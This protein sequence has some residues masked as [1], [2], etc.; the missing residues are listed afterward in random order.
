LS[1]NPNATLPG[2]SGLLRLGPQQN[3][4]R[5]LSWATIKDG[6]VEAIERYWK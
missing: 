1:A 2:A 3:I 5:Q 6:L 4:I